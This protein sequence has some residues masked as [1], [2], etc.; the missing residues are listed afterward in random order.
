M[1]QLKSVN[2][3][4]DSKFNHSRPNRPDY[5]KFDLSRITNITAN[6][7][8]IIPFDWFETLPGDFLD[9]ENLLSL[10]TLPLVQPSLT[11][12]KV[13]IHWYYMDL[14]DMWNTQVN[15]TSTTFS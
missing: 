10:D 15:I 12:Y 3:A 2:G 11:G 1:N 9:I 13:L 7:G 5:S 6:E 4:S 14:K 8:M